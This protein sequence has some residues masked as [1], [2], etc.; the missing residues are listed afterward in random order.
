MKSF[1]ASR[2]F[3][4]SGDCILRADVGRERGAEDLDAVGVGAVDELGER[5]LELLGGDDVVGFVGVVGVAD[6]VDAFEDD[7]VL[8]AALVEHVAVEAG[9]RVGAGD[10]VQDAVAADA[11]VEHA[12]VGGL[13]VGLQAACEDVGPAHVLVG[14]AV[15]AV[16]DAVAE[17]DDRGG[18]GGVARTSTA[19]R[20]GQ[21]RRVVAPAKS[22]E[23]SWLPASS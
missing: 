20:N 10:V 8:H 12:E 11:F 23:A 13:L 21:E 1:S 18:V 19:L 2:T 7:E 4:P 16:G 5:H 3:S 14:C 6:V 17:G 9:E 22:A 15:G